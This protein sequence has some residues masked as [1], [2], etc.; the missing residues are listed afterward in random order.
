MVTI[1]K[2]IISLFSLYAI[3]YVFMHHII[4][5]LYLYFLDIVPY[6]FNNPGTNIFHRRS[7]YTFYLYLNFCIEIWGIHSLHILHHWIN[8]KRELSGSFWDIT[9]EHI[10]NLY[11][12]VL[13]CLIFKNKYTCTIYKYLC[14]SNI[15]VYYQIYLIPFA[16]KMSI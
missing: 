2:Y 13:K 11:V 8:Y 1:C 15:T 3:I 14:S 5:R 10:Y 7:L 12:K 6:F 16:V 4:F 9:K